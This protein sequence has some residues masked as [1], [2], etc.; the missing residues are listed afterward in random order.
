MSRPLLPLVVCTI[1]VFQLICFVTADCAASENEVLKPVPQLLSVLPLDS[2]TLVLHLREGSIRYHQRGEPRINEAAIVTPLAIDVA[3]LPET[4]TLEADGQPPLKPAKVYRKSKGYE[5]AWMVQSWKNGRAVN[6]D[7]D[8]SKD[9][10]LYL[11]FD[12]GLEDGKTYRLHAPGVLPQEG[13]E[14]TH[15]PETSHSAAIHVNTV[16]FAPNAPVKFAYVFHWMGDGGAYEPQDMDGRRFRVV[17]AEGDTTVFEGALKFRKGADNPETGHPADSP[18]H[19][20]FLKAPVWEA[21]LSTITEPGTYRVV[22]DGLGSSLPFRISPAVHRDPYYHVARGLYHNRSGIALEK[23]FTEYERPAPH[24]PKLTPGFAGRLFY[25]TKR[26][27][28][29]GSEG[30]D[31]RDLRAHAKGP[32]DAWGWYQDAGDWDAY[33]S[34]LSVPQHLLTSFELLP[35]QHLDGD[36]NI[37]E[38]G[39]GVPDLLDEAAWLPRFF[40]RLRH[41]LLE[42]K[43]GTGGVGSRV[44]GDAFGTDEKILPD[45]TSVAQGSWEDVNRDWAVSGEDPWSTYRYAGVAAHLA[46]CLKL[47]GVTDPE[48]VDWERE[49]LESYNWA[50][51]NTLPRDDKATLAPHKAYAA[52]NLFRLTGDRRFEAD[53][54]ECAADIR[55]DTYLTDD[56]RFAPWSYALSGGPEAPNP[57]EHARIRQ[58]VVHSARE[59]VIHTPSKRALRWGG[60]F[61]MPMLVGQQTTPWVLD[62]AV[63][64]KLTNESDPAEAEKLLTG[65]HTTA[66]FFLGGNA[67]DMTWITKVGHNSPEQIFHM[68]SWYRPSGFSPGMIPYG[69]WRDEGKRAEGPW[70]LAWP[71]QTVYPEIAQWPGGERWFNNRCSPLAAEFTVHQQNGPAAAFYGFL[72][73]FHRS[74]KTS[75]TALPTPDVTE[76]TESPAAD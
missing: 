53:F 68:D 62:G 31:A 7:A 69:P 38:S 73:A 65:L 56:W 34:H 18:P 64:W 75:A 63:G 57:A 6:H 46:Y 10:W 14:Y 76:N 44:A 3:M 27:T 54:L 67:L 47:V 35:E 60:N 12:R 70:H 45:G 32:L 19:G 58:A 1:F 59:T 39:N 16:G 25:T 40:H 50:A 5:F 41:E 17:T 26:W 13:V 15:S 28:D 43:Y 8:H 37:P 9:H 49:A 30:G 66:D 42:K 71:H 4:Y 21:D 2:S 23:P 72:Y 29:W 61:Y 55:G 33:F 24:N 48:G 11:V 52:A 20:N 51:E 22:V 36:L 74:G